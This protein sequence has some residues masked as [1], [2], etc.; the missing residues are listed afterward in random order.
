[1][2]GSDEIYEWNVD[3]KL[4]NYEHIPSDNPHWWSSSATRCPTGAT[5][6][7]RHIRCL[8]MAFQTPS[9]D[10][11]NKSTTDMA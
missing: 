6:Y 1:M 4:R 9:S 2:W 11:Y 5:A 3:Q 8:N 7:K 10:S